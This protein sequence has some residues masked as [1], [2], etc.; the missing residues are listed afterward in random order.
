MWTARECSKNGLPDQRKAGITAKKLPEQVINS[1]AYVK[2]FFNLVV[3]SAVKFNVEH[4]IC[5]DSFSCVRTIKKY[6][7]QT[8]D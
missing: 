8:R 4:Y 7:L 2:D 1:K 6:P 5:G 3:P